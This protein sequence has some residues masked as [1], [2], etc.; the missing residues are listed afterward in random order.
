VSAETLRAHAGQLEP[1]LVPRA[2]HVISENARVLAATE[3]LRRGDWDGLGRLLIASHRSLRD[4]FE[5]SC[6]ELDRIVSIACRISGVLGARLVGGGFGGRV[7]VL[8]R[9]HA[10]DVLRKALGANCGATVAESMLQVHA[11]RGASF[12]WV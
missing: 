2:S 12:A 10:V 1:S 11:A 3:A 4:D 5:V 9:E 7:L 8:A 6:R